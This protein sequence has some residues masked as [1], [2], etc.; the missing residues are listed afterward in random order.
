MKLLVDED[1]QAKR[2]I[3]LLREAGHDILTA[4][5]ARLEQLSDREVLAAAIEM[6]R[7]VLTRNGRDFLALHLA[8]RDHAG[9]LVVNQ[10]AIPSKNMSHVAIVRAIGNLEASGWTP[11]GE[12]VS[13]TA[14]QFE[15]D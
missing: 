7:S 15:L 4:S 1:S 12:F 14:W 9:I 11:R 2:L 6:N 10:D 3:K 13:L 5:E 8:I